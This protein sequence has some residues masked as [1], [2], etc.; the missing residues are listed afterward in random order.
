MTFEEKTLKSEKIYDGVII[1]L[2][3][4][5]V[6][7]QGGTSYREIVEHNGGAVMA[8]LTEDKTLVMVR[9]YRK[10]ADKVMLEVPAGKIDPG[11]MPLEAAVRELK[12]ETG[13]TASKVEF[14]TEFYPSVGYSE[15]RLYLYL[16]TGLTPGETCFDENEAIEIEEIDLDRLF[17]MAMSGELDDAKT[18]IAILM[19][20]A[21]VG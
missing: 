5:K 8:A 16:C 3:R 1:N 7:V 15:E 11:E 18:I 14:L 17:K 4:D 6:T 2:R 12:E 20:K 10:P 21:L 9:Q 19:V 13:Y